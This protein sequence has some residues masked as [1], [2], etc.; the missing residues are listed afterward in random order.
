MT[1]AGIQD[2]QTRLEGTYKE[3]LEKTI[4]LHRTGN[5]NEAWDRLS[6]QITELDSDPCIRNEIKAEF[7]YRMAIW[8]LEDKNSI[9]KAQKKFDKPW[10]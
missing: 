9:A 3:K 7:Y 2:L 1:I 8:Y 6:R 5:V 10:N 4:E